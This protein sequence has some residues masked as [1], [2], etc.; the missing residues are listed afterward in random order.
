[1]SPASIDT[2]PIAPKPL[3]TAAVGLVLG[4]LGGIAIA[5]LRELQLD[6]IRSIDDL[7]PLEPGAVVLAAVPHMTG[8]LDDPMPELPR[9]ATEGL[10]Y[11]RTSLRFRGVR[12]FVMTSAVEQEG[13]TTIAVNLARAMAAAG[14]RVVL[15]DA[16][17]RRPSVHARTGTSNE[18]GLSDVLCG[19]ATLEDALQYPQGSLAVL[20]AGRSTEQAHELLTQEL[21]GGVIRALRDQCDLLI[22]DAPP[23]LMVADPLVAAEAVDGAA[24]VVRVGSVKRREVR[25]ALRRLREANLPVVGLVANDL[26][27]S[28]TYGVYSADTE[29]APSRRRRRAVPSSA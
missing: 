29:A 11:L 12:S 14:D 21:F 23:L 1:V 28:Q 15:V 24:L 13:K 10:N 25:S 5:V 9:Q 20:P 17:L 3:R 26:D 18:V 19:E 4:L 22:V 27:L 6:R 7:E 16:D 8:R 2:S